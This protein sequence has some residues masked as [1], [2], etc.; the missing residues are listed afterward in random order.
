MAALRISE[1]GSLG[2]LSISIILNIIF[3]TRGAFTAAPV[4]L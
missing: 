2:I 4:I 3:F 1:A